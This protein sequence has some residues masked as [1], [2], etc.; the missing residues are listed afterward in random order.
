MNG[1]MSEE[2]TPADQAKSFPDSTNLTPGRGGVIP[3]VENRWRKGE[4]GNPKGRPSIGCTLI[5]HLN[6]LG[7]KSLS[8]KQLLKI[9]R[10]QDEDYLVVSAANAILA[11]GER[12][13]LADF[14]DLLSGAMDADELREEGIDTGVLKKIKE[15]TRY[16]P[17]GDGEYDREVTREI[18]GHDRSRA[19]LT[20][21]LEHTNGKPTQTTDLNINVLPQSV[22]ITTPRTRILDEQPIIDVGSVGADS[23]DRR[24]L[25]AAD[26]QQPA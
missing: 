6:I 15:T 1:G 20:L 21:V 4:S 5:E 8:K 18:E 12:V 23:G 19:A 13:D 22:R 16:V 3:P 11:L 26:G 9:S 14:K 24:Q 25:P 7:A 17:S 2:E 10:D